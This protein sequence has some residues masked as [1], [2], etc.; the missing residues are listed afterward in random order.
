RAGVR[1][2][3][4]L[5]PARTRAHAGAR[6]GPRASGRCPRRAPA[7]CGRAPR[8]RRRRAGRRHAGRADGIAGIR[9]EEDERADTRSEGDAMKM[10]WLFFVLCVSP[11]AAQE[12]PSRPVKIVVTFTPGGGAD[13]TARVFAD[14]LSEV[15]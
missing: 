15:W 7:R 2:D 9:D 12:F 14:R 3:R 1:D 13:T 4:L 10:L 6:R 11:V 8:D 5:R